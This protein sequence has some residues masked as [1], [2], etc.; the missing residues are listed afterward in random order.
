MHKQWFGLSARLAMALAALA[1]LVQ[2]MSF[3]T[4]NDLRNVAL[5]QS[6]I[7]KVKLIAQ[8]I[9]PELVQVTEQTHL[10]AR[11]LLLQE[12]LVSAMQRQGAQRS[13]VIAQLLARNY[14]ESRVD[15]LEVTDEEGRVLYRAQEPGRSGDLASAWGVA[16]ALAGSSSLVSEKS[17]SGPFILAIEP[18]RVND[19][20]VGT[21]SVGVKIGDRLMRALNAELGAH[22]A[23][24]AR[25]GELVASSDS[26]KLNPD[27]SAIQEAFQK[28]IPIYRTNDVM[29]TTLVYL[30]VLIV[31]E[32]WVIMTQIDSL[33]AFEMLKKGDHQAALNMLAVVVAAVLAILLI[34]W[35]GLT[36]LRQLRQRSEQL[37]T[38]LAGTAL[39]PRSR[40]D[41]ASVVTTLEA[42]T[43]LLLARNQTLAEQAEQR[44]RDQA[45]ADRQQQVAAAEIRQLAY[46]DAL[47]ELPNRRHFLML[48]E[49]AVSDSQHHQRHE[50]L[51]FLDLDKF[52]ALNDTLGHDMGDLL[53]QQVAQR[54][55]GC[56]RD[57][58]TA[59]RLGGDEFV[60][61]L[62]ALSEDEEAAIKEATTAGTSILQALNETYHLASFEYHCTV[63]IGITL[64]TAHCGGLGELMKRAD[65]AM[66]HAKCA[67]RNTL[68]FFTSAMQADLMARTD[69]EADLQQAILANQFLLHYQ[70]Q[71]SDGQITGAEVLVRWQHP[72][73]G[74]V[75]PAEFIPLAEETGMILPLGAWVLD[76]ACAQ[77]ALWARLPG[78]SHLCL[79]VNVS[80]REFRQP[81]FVEQVLAT[82]ERTGANPHRLKLELTESLLVL[83]ME[84]VIAKMAVLKARGVGFSLDDFGTGYSSLSYL[85]RLPLD[86]LKIDQ[87]FVRDILL[88]PNDAAIAK[89]VIALADSMGLAVIAEGVE[90]QAQK[91]LLATL[92]CHAYQGYLFSRPLPLSEFEQLLQRHEFDLQE[93]RL[94]ALA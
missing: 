43:Q 70:L 35:F 9:A 48:L 64:F 20:V 41:I 62:R 58:D 65:I 46:Y 34:L 42:L 17:S 33:P 79:S 92:G 61:L 36:P 54:I 40:D 80:A 23:L 18:I 63:S 2:W 31:D 19:K 28:K 32:A 77:L 27:V 8:V 88:D 67:S 85:K 71:T 66:Y 53:L 10:I 39:G 68:R 74:L 37:L 75:S 72:Q 14:R 5:Q 49:K 69:M 93:A 57:G 16:E 47:T 21:L 81:V 50:A 76:D 51:L 30:P 25:S 86:Q 29:H 3:Q 7:S 83:D 26:K 90:T 89:M 82:L 11:L 22:F 24:L 45:E 55:R 56:I 38:T 4:S 52:K 59:A 44:T 78:R 6:E 13:A 94:A 87:S 1:L 84:D 12:S 15:L 73:R 91:E 60:V